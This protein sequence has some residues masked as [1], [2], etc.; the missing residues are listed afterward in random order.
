MTRE[1]RSV[2]IQDSEWRNEVESAVEFLSLIDADDRLLYINHVQPSLEDY[3]GEPVYEFIL[4]EHHDVVRRSIE[5]ARAT[6]LPQHYESEAAGLD[7]G[8]ALYSNWI[9]EIAQNDGPGVVA[10]VA[11]DITS[12]RRVE[13]ELVRSDVTLRSLLEHAPDHIMIVD[14]ERRLKFV[15]RLD[16]GFK[17]ADVMGQP[18]EGFVRADEREKVV[19]AVESVIRTGER[20]SYQT[21]LHSP[22]G[23]HDF[24]TRLG[25][26]IVDDQVDSVVMI[27]TDIT[28][29][30][31]A[32]RERE[33]LN[34][35]LQHSQ[36]IDALGQLTGGVAHDFNNL[37][38]AIGGNLELLG[39]AGIDDKEGATYLAE[40]LRAVDRAADLTRRLLVFARKQPLAP[41]T[42]RIAALIDDMA[43]LL[44]RTIGETISVRAVSADELWL[45]DIDRGQLEQAILNLAVNA[46]D[47]MPTG[48]SLAIVSENRVV[49]EDEATEQLPAGDYVSVTVSDTGFGMD[50][51][52]VAQAFEPFFS[53]KEV[54]HGTGLGLSMVYGFASQS[55]GHV[56]LSSE[57]G[58]GTTVQMLLPR[59][60]Q[61]EPKPADLAEPSVKRGNGEV[62]LVVEDQPI[63]REMCVNLLERLGY[64]TLEAVD[65]T[66][67][68]ATLD[69]RP[70]IAL[71]LSDVGLPGEMDGYALASR[72]R[73]WDRPVPVVL[74]SGYAN[75]AASTGR[76]P[77]GFP[78]LPKPFKLA[79][80]ADVVAVALVAK[81]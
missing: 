66:Q 29:T 24:L 26:I 38:T 57:L 51:D 53:T 77:G 18:V 69:A 59:G 64:R 27:S 33:R 25:P 16:F 71:M 49:D 31:V 34:A 43:P 80:L 40:A 2:S 36:K 60:G 8:T 62:V 54:G 70:D 12:L 68:C 1:T 56:N 32:E 65:A 44:R 4:P 46:R 37:L 10:F 13:D 76:V 14:R 21:T 72:I 52:V 47:A 5:A 23:D 78:F 63:V 17:P 41:K 42:E 9:F 30:R 48:G 22:T 19:E 75:K 81:T 67:A 6:G 74:M 55:G 61:E 58:E 7:G 20:R 28:A 35:Q 3:A 11:T 15:N 73:S 50:A 45:A 79:E 39:A